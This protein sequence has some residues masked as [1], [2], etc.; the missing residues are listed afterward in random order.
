[1][2]NRVSSIFLSSVILVVLTLGAPGIL[3]AQTSSQTLSQ[4]SS[5]SSNTPQIAPEVVVS[6]TR[7]ETPAEQIGS[8]ITVF[9]AKDIEERNPQF[10]E[11]IL[12]FIPGVDVGQTGGVPGGLAQVR[13]RGSEANHTLVIIDGV[14][15]NRPNVSNE[16]DF[17]ALRPEDIERI[18]VLRGPQTALYGSEAIGGVVNIITKTGNGK[19][20]FTLTQEFGSDYTRNTHVSAL[21]GG[22]IAKGFSYNARISGSGFRT[23]G[24]S[25]ASLGSEDDASDIEDGNAKLGLSYKKI[26]HLDLVGRFTRSDVKNDNTGDPALPFGVGALDN[27]SST[28]TRDRYGRAQVRLNLFEGMW[29][30]KFGLS[31][32]HNVIQ[33]KAA[34]GA[35]T[36]RNEGK[37]TIWDYQSVFNVETK[38][39]LNANH[40]LILGYENEDD[41]LK[42]KSSFSSTLNEVNN[43]NFYFN[44]HLGLA[45]R[46]F[47]TGGS[48]LQYSDFFP[49]VDVEDSYRFTAAYLHRETKTKIKGAIGR[50]IKNPTLFELFGS[51]NNFVANPNLK[52]ERTESWELGFEQSFLKDKLKLDVV[53]FDNQ[54]KDLISGSGTTS[55]NIA[56]VSIHGVEFS[57]KTRPLKNVDVIANYTWMTSEQ[58]SGAD[59][60]SVLVRRPKHKANVNLIY[61][62]LQDKA[63]AGVNFLYNGNAQDFDFNRSFARRLTTLDS[64]FLVNLTGSYKFSDGVKLFGRID[65]LFGQNY[66]EVFGFGRPGISGFGGIK[67]TF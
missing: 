44:Y 7:V 42:S 19:P 36:F 15:V 58:K 49:N 22:K 13:I 8:A 64:Y 41:R 29:K 33:S 50:G 51:S 65:N 66:E 47:F 25:A 26:A 1:M 4:S 52:P 40:T 45:K 46:F 17:F 3:Q 10:V 60:G 5:G 28:N 11:D 30:Q 48:Q 56:G 12:R 14:E 57:V 21:A 2:G 53:Y 62:F 6:A 54:V 43:N 18:E 35:V 27:G 63:N 61:R 38:K 16:F 31:A 39:L 32:T 59:V 24:I 55:T 23:D 9:T 34:S 67:L 37:K 20:K